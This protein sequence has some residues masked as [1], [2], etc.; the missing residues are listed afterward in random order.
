MTNNDKHPEQWWERLPRILGGWAGALVVFL[1]FPFPEAELADGTV[2]LIEPPITAWVVWVT[3][4]V[5][6][7]GIA[8]STVTGIVLGNVTK[9]IAA[10]R[11]ALKGKRSSSAEVVVQDQATS[12]TSLEGTRKRPALDVRPP[13]KPRGR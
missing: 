12:S 13:K 9:A 7:V 11:R 10:G 5:F 2:V 3:L 1:F 8:H 6:F 4:I